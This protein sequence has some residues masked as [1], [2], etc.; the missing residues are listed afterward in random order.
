MEKN[1]FFSTET[2]WPSPEDIWKHV[3]IFLVVTM[4]WAYYW[5]LGRFR[6]A[7]H[8]A[9]YRTSLLNEEFLSQVL[10]LLMRFSGDLAAVWRQEWGKDNHGSRDIIRIAVALSKWE[11]MM[12]RV[13]LGS[14]RSR[15]V[16]RWAN[17][18]RH[19][20]LGTLCFL[21]NKAQSQSLS[22]HHSWQP[23]AIVFS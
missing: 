22:Q 3:G 5:D 11:K 6:D 18:S 14:H 10:V 4:I 21:L 23:S 12:T 8:P 2:V 19:L 1:G 13:G 9:M 16:K 17:M 20:K 7:K 15:T